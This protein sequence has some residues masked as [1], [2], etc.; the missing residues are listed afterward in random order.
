MSNVIF[1]RYSNTKANAKCENRALWVVSDPA[2]E[3]MLAVYRLGVF[4][5]K[6]VNT[7]LAGSPCN[8]WYKIFYLVFL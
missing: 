4:K 5:F 6:G 3:G 1:T 8:R 7:P 2:I